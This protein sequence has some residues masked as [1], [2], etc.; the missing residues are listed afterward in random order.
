MIY[1]GIDPGLDGAVAA[2]SG[3]PGDLPPWI[4][5]LDT[6]TAKDG[7]K[8][9]YLVADMRQ[10]LV[11]LLG[12]TN[13]AALCDAY[14]AIERVHSM[15]KQGVAS[16]FTFGEGFGLWQGVLTGLGIPFDLVTPQRWKKTLLDGASKEKDASRIRAQQLFPTVDLKLK[17]HHGRADALLIAE[18]RRRQG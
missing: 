3:N 16:S 2:I 12:G 4:V 9:R 15:P 1:L 17:K 13:G 8:R 6:P 5:A 11:K 10:M 14:A 18:W 7:T